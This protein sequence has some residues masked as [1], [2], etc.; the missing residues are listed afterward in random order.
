LSQRGELA[1]DAREL[2]KSYGRIRALRGVDLKV[3]W[4][5]FVVVL[6]PNGAGKTTLIKVLSSA[7][8]PTSGSAFV[9]GGKLGSE[10][11]RSAVGVVSHRS[12]LYPNLTAEENLTFYGRLYGMSD[13]GR[14]AERLLRAVGVYERAGD[15][16]K[17]LSSGMLKRVSLARALINDPEILLLDEP[18]SGLDVEGLSS[19]RDM[20]EGFRRGGGTVLMTTHDPSRGFELYDRVVV[21]HDGRILCDLDARGLSLGEIEEIYLGHTGGRC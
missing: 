11:A 16:V 18:F 6:G 12:F 20:L 4:G 7:A 21:L 17:L 10:A 2:T 5:E 8:K 15:P 3:G 19:F 13:L 1:I 14:R 9:A